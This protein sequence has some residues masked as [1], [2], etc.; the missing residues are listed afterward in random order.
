MTTPTSTGY[1]VVDNEQT[2]YGY[3]PTTDLA[4]ADLLRTLHGAQVTILDDDA[5]S[6]DFPGSWTRVSGFRILPASAALLDLV[7]TAGGLCGWELIGGVACTEDEADSEA[8]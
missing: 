6:S 5:D 2:I 3:G 7:D 1:I 4:W 8:A